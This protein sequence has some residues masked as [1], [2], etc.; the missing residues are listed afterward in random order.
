MKTLYASGKPEKAKSLLS[1]KKE[2]E[3]L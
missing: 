1:R 2:K 3:H